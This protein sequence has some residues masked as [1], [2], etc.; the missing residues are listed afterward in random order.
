M[1]ISGCF[2]LGRGGWICTLRARPI[3]HH[4]RFLD[5][6]KV[7]E[8]Y[9]DVFDTLWHLQKNWT[10]RWPLPDGLDGQYS[11]R[12]PWQQCVEL[13]SQKGGL[14]KPSQTLQIASAKELLLLQGLA[15]SKGLSCWQ[16]AAAR[17]SYVGQRLSHRKR[18][19]QSL[20]SKL[21]WKTFLVLKCRILELIDVRVSILLR[22][23]SFP[24]K[25]GLLFSL[26]PTLNRIFSMIELL[27]HTSL[28]A[29]HCRGFF[30]AWCPVVWCE[31]R[32]NNP[33]GQV[34]FW[35]HILVTWDVIFR[36]I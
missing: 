5:G 14:L 34:E 25:A 12:A 20:E 35:I 26:I 16:S 22:M 8:G 23:T 17:D 36:Y 15:Y 18:K 9:D 10:S 32:L 31:N 21:P 28:K 19:A 27:G 7:G 4:L 11:L 2:S 29:G 13:K 1:S 6:W 30:F 24:T 3:A 33:S